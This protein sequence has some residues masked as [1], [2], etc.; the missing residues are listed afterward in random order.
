MG[1]PLWKLDIETTSTGQKP[2]A[3]TTLMFRNR[4]TGNH[5]KKSTQR[6]LKETEEHTAKLPGS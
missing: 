5:H 4:I 6:V 1:N 2:I 3:T